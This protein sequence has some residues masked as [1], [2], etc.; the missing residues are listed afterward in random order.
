MPEDKSAEEEKSNQ[1]SR[2]MVSLVRKGSAVPWSP[3]NEDPH[4]ETAPGTLLGC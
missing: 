2:S 1:G 4:L 3:P